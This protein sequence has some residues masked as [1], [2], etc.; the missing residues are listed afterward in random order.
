MS[1]NIAAILRS[2]ELAKQQRISAPRPPPPSRRP[3]DED[4]ESW[5][6]LNQF[7]DDYETFDIPDCKGVTPG[8]V[9]VS[10]A[11][12]PKSIHVAGWSVPSSAFSV[13]PS[14]VR[15]IGPLVRTASCPLIAPSAPN[16]HRRGWLRPCPWCGPRQPLLQAHRRVRLWPDREDQMNSILNRKIDSALE[17]AIGATFLFAMAYAGWS[18]GGIHAGV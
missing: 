18:L 6:R 7:Y 13:R 3:V 1:K 14:A 5:A 11:A 4:A 12:E 16:L 10:R 9:P 2:V 8:L 15:P 17:Y